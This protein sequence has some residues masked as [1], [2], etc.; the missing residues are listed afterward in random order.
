IARVSAST[1][2]G[3][4]LLLRLVSFG[5]GAGL[6]IV[7]LMF[8]ALAVIAAYG[9]VRS[10]PWPRLFQAR[11]SAALAGISAL[12][13]P[14][15]LGRDDL[16]QYTADAF[17]ALMILWLVSRLESNWTRRRLI[18]VGGVVVV[19]FLFSAV[20]VFVG[21][22]AFGSLLLVALIRRNWSQAIESAAV[23]AASGVILGLTFLAL[24]KPGIPPGLT[25]YWG[26][27]YLPIAQGWGPT[28]KFLIA[29]VRPL[30]TSYLGMGSML[31]AVPLI[32]VGVATLGSLRRFATGLVVPVLAAEMVILGAIKQYPFLDFRTS[33][34]LTTALAVTVAVGIGGIGTVLSRL[35]VAASAA[36]A[37]LAV[38]LLLINP[39]VRNAV[40]A[41]PIPAE[42]LRTP[43]RYIEG[44][45]QPDDVIVVAMLSSWGFAYYSSSGTPAIEPVTSNLQQFVTIFPDRPNV[46][47]ATDRTVAAVDAVMNRAAAAAATIGPTA[48]V[49][50]IHQ[51][52]QVAELKAF[53]AAARAHGF[54]V[55]SVIKNSLDLL[56]RT[57][58]G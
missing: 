45:Q 8:S 35:H 23:G 14:S 53:S 15:A 11:L 21:A 34:F 10:L 31:V 26:A 4:S 7:P 44:H 38:A 27:S 51:H 16:K 29:H 46:L 41:K 6:R 24:Y 12:M 49:W 30:A 56:T 9:Y 55:T 52:A 20:A 39:Q 5:G 36:V 22:A 2:V 18:A 3:W 25:T 50:I 32:V 43:T 57:T 28:W 17:V 58:M 47:V 1:P 48:R 37:L 54:A 19:G 13:T 40:R 42:D 33:H